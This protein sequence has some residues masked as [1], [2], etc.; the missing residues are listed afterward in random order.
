[1]TPDDKERGERLFETETIQYTKV[2]NEYH[3]FWVVDPETH[4]VYLM[5]FEQ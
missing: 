5:R 4:T 1:M 2:R 3:D